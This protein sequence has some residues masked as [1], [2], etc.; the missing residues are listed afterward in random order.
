MRKVDLKVAQKT[1]TGIKV[2]G[3]HPLTSIVMA[4]AI[5]KMKWI[6]LRAFVHVTKKVVL[7]VVELAPH[8]KNTDEVIEE[9]T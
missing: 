7:K 9:T 5:G 2:V 3:T 8:P 6:A 1:V 4:V